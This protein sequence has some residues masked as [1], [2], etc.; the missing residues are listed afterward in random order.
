MQLG[1]PGIPQPSHTETALRVHDLWHDDTGA[2][3]SVIG[4]WTG[5]FPTVQDACAFAEKQ[6]LRT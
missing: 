1:L 6:G 4:V 3:L 5:R 2:Y